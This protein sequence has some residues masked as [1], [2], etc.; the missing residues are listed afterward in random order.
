MS[1]ETYQFF[2]ALGGT[3]V[4]INQ[5]EPDRIQWMDGSKVETCGHR[6]SIAEFLAGY[7]F[8][9]RKPPVE[10]AEGAR[11]RSWWDLARALAAE[12]GP[13][14]LLA[15]ESDKRR[16]KARVQRTDART[17]ASPL[18]DRRFAGDPQASGRGPSAWPNRP[19]GSPASWISTR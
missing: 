5:R 13:D 11:A 16:Q 1:I 12:A 18:A 3:L 4:Y 10:V 9:S 14:E 15:F 6:L 2:T 8:S 17:R 7:G 19:G